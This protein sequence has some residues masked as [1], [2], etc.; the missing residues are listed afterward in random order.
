MKTLIAKLNVS[1]VSSFVKSVLPML[2]LMGFIA[3][4]SGGVAFAQ[5]EAGTLSITE[6]VPQAEWTSMITDV[7][8]KIGAVVK[9]M[10]GVAIGLLIVGILFRV[11]RKYASRGA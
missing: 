8:T 10:L 6:V 3:F 7:G 4:A 1:A 9:A 11:V 5:G 2:L